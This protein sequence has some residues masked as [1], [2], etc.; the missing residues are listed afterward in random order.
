MAAVPGW[1]AWTSREC[2]GADSLRVP[3]RPS[4]AARAEN[5]G[6]TG[7]LA[8][9]LSDSRVMAR[10]SGLRRDR[11]WPPGTDV[12]GTAPAGPP[13]PNPLRGR[14]IVSSVNGKPGI[15]L[16]WPLAQELS[17]PRSEGP[18]SHIA[19]GRP[20]PR[21]CPPDHGGPGRSPLRHV[22]FPVQVVERPHADL[23]ESC[24]A[25][26][27]STSGRPAGQL[28]G[29]WFSSRKCFVTGNLEHN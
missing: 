7:S 5:D 11:S 20:A 14:R 15:G 22:M 27:G 13:R 21:P 16:P 28:A 17:G 2:L 26:F 9:H 19:C 8:Q 10:V 23:S 18:T 12:P 25:W 3:D 4:P 29:S 24:H 1:T 6:T